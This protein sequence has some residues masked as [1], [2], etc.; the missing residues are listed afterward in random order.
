MTDTS[1]TPTGSYSSQTVQVVVDGKLLT[2]PTAYVQALDALDKWLYIEDWEAVNIT[3]GTA[4]ARYVAGDPLWLRIIGASGAGKT[5]LLRAIA[6]H[7]DSFELG[8][9]TPAAIGGGYKEGAK[10]LQY[11]DGKRVVTLDLSAVITKNKETRRQLFGL[12]RHIYDGSLVSAFG[13]PEG[14]L[15]QKASFDW[16]LAATP[17]IESQ[18]NLDAE[19]GERF[20]DLRPRL[21]DAEAAAARAVANAPM[22][23]QMRQELAEAVI[24]LLDFCKLAPTP[25]IHPNIEAAIPKLVNLMTLFRTPVA[26]DRLHHVSYVPQREIGTRAGQS[27]SRL[28]KGLALIKG[29]QEVG[30]EEYPGLLRVAADS[31]PSTRRKILAEFLSGKRE[32][33]ELEKATGFSTGQVSELLQDL[34]LLRIKEGDKLLVDLDKA[35]ITIG[36]QAT[37]P[38][39]IGYLEAIRRQ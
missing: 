22:V 7:T 2:L 38:L 28:A 4:A 36:G 37:W 13:S 1:T 16:L 21:Y 35:A 14:I 6:G 11:V 12:L 32:M 25:Q 34:E 31:I 8:N 18:R 29:K 24:G 15:P 23:D 33:G 9:L 26:R 19:L 20:I 5:E 39:K 3:L 17:A 30:W 10:L 27:L